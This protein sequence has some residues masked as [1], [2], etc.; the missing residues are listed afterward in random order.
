[1]KVGGLIWKAKNDIRKILRKIYRLMHKL[2]IGADFYFSAHTIVTPYTGFVISD[3]YYSKE[4]DEYHFQWLNPKALKINLERCGNLKEKSV[5][6]CQADQLEKFIEKYL[7]LIKVPFILITGKWH[8]PGVENEN[9]AKRMLENPFLVAWFSQN[10]IFEDL[11]IHPFPFGVQIEKSRAFARTKNPSKNRVEAPLIPFS[12]IHDHTPEKYR[13]FRVELQSR[14]KELKSFKEYQL[15]LKLHKYVVCTPGDRPDTHRHWEA[16]A[17]GAI[18]ILVD[19]ANF[20]NLFGES[21]LYVRDFGDESIEVALR[22]E[23]RLNSDLIKVSYW[24]EKVI[25]KFGG[26]TDQ[27]FNRINDQ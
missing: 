21:A 25:S 3:Y 23:H 8:F 11:S 7:S 15:D 20:K 6:Y 16:L 2:V 17:S 10:Q 13:K 24:K 14:M 12:T 18:P 22:S 5:I 19:Q 26:G 9:V 27:G 1:M 4:I